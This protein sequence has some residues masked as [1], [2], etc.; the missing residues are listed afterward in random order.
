MTDSDQIAAALWRLD[1]R[2]RELLELSLG[3]RVPDE[4]MAKVMGCEPG[5]VARRRAGAIE[6]LADELGVERGEEL[7]DVLKALLEPDI[8]ESVREP[9]PPAD[10][11]PRAEP[12]LEIL[13]H[14]ADAKPA[15]GPSPWYVVAGCGA[16]IVL[17]AGGFAAAETVDDGDSPPPAPR[18]GERLFV[19]QAGGPLAAP[20]ASDPGIARRYLTALVRR[21]TVL[22]DEPGGRVRLRIPSRTEWRSPRVL[23][24]VEQR[25]R[26]LAVQVS[27]LPN[28]EVGWLPRERATLGSVSWSLHADLSKRRLEARRSG[29]TVMRMRV[30]VGSPRHPTPRG[31]FAV[32]DKLRVTDR[33][34]PYGCCVLAL[35]GHQTR[36]PPDWPGG[37]RLAVHATRDS[38]SIGRAVSL[39]CMRASSAHTSRLIRR[40]PLGTPIFIHR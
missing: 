19:P 3:R 8:W 2:Q 18:G 35:T 16:A 27:E 38:D 31:R 13:G 10:Q 15:S 9:D 21:P 24:V 22:Y 26:W 28:G 36:L 17:A 4:A 23:G 14:E 11:S 29:R 20:F 6:R 33:D 30:A 34:S 1:P 32:T 39:G 37:D 12:V 5:E 40:V 7:G 25:G